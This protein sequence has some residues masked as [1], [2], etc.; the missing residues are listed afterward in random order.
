MGRHFPRHPDPKEGHA[1][2][3]LEPGKHSLRYRSF[4]IPL[5]FGRIQRN[6]LPTTSVGVGNMDASVSFDKPG[7]RLGIIGRIGEGIENIRAPLLRPLDQIR[8]GLGVVDRGR[9]HQDRE[10]D[11]S[12]GRMNVDLE[13]SPPFDIPLAVPLAAPIA[14]LGDCFCDL[15]GAH[16]GVK[17]E[18]RDVVRGD[19]TLF[20]LLLASPLFGRALFRFLLP[21]G[22]LA[23]FES[24]AVNGGVLHEGASHMLPDQDPVDPLG[25]VQRGELGEDSGKGRLA[26]NLTV[27]PSAKAP[28]VFVD[29][30]AGD[31]VPGACQPQNRLGDERPADQGP[32][33]GGAPGPLMRL[34]DDVFRPHDLEN[35]GDFL[36]IVRHGT[37]KSVI[38]TGKEGALNSSPDTAELVHHRSSSFG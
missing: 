9:G 18:S 32:F 27:L 19:D 21:D 34:T 38:Q 37:G 5:L 3:L 25:H 29:L 14:A 33:M 17:V 23:S 1:E 2:I 36:V 13:P 30:Q 6:L 31:Q 12:L 16:P 35:L 8:D 4:F 28:K 10:R 22:L 7:D 15:S 24:R 20:A 26:G 11:L